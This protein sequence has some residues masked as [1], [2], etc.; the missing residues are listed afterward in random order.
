MVTNKNNN[1]VQVFGLCMKFGLYSIE[2]NVV[3]IAF[4]DWSGNIFH[5]RNGE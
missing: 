4:V 5:G 3:F 2:G 1:S